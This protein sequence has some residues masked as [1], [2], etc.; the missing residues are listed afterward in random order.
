MSENAF[1]PRNYRLS[2]II[3][4][5]GKVLAMTEEGVLVFEKVEK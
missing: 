3:A 4:V 2:F 1:T 5:D